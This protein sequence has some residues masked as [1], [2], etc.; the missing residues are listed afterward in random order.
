M[1]GMVYKIVI[2]LKWNVHVFVFCILSAEYFLHII[3]IKKKLRDEI[4]K[5]KKK[6]KKKKNK[7]E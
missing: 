5:K 1:Y 4:T 2:H 3:E 6:K 7:E